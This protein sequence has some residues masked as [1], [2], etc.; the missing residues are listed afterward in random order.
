MSDFKESE[1]IYAKDIG[2]CDECP[3]YESG[4]CGGGMRSGCGGVPI[5]P[6]CFSWDDDTIVQEGDVERARIAYEDELDRR[7]ALERHLKAQ[8]A[9][10]IR[11]K[12]AHLD[13]KYKKFKEWLPISPWELTVTQRRKDRVYLRAKDKRQANYYFNLETEKFYV[14]HGKPSLL[15]YSIMNRFEND[16]KEMYYGVRP[17]DR[18][19]VK[20][21]HEIVN[22]IIKP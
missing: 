9:T 2:D 5:E 13:S 6:P 19:F 3:L 16:F 15:D 20:E 12:Y 17:K 1:V 11:K 18:N 10:E 21:V 4:E 7:E 8:R 14:V 22:Q